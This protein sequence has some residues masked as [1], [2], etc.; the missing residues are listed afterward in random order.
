[1]SN[2][3]F[4]WSNTHQLFYMRGNIDSYIR[5]R[6]VPFNSVTH[7]LQVS[8][9]NKMTFYQSTEDIDRD[10]EEGK[11]FFDQAFT[12]AYIIAA[13]EQCTSHK[14]FYA[15]L[16]G[17]VLSE[18]PNQKLLEY[19]RTLLDHY[20]HSVAYFRSTQEGPTRALVEKVAA[21]VSQDELNTLLLSPELDEINKETF[22]WQE[23]MDRGF[24]RE[25]AL[26]HLKKYPWLC[27]NALT[28]ED[29]LDEL[30]QRA[31]ISMSHD[32]RKEKEELR[33]VQTEILATYQHI[34]QDVLTLQRMALLRPEVK[35]AWAASGY[36]AISILI[37]VAKRFKIDFGTLTFL[38]RHEDVE[39]LLDMGKVLSTQE[40]AE[41]NRCTAYVIREDNLFDFVGAEA[42]Q[43][44]REELGEADAI[45][46]VHEL[47]GMAA[48]PGKFT[49]V[50]YILDVNDPEAARK[51]RDTFRGGVLVT[52]MTQPNI[53][54]IAKW[55]SAIV[56]DEG[57]ML[58]HAAIISR[59]FSIPC[60]VGTHKATKV[61]KD[62]DMVE[63][64]ADKGVVRI[65]TK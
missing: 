51:F 34:G 41:R 9:G 58:S 27:Q 52:S 48:R 37:E 8:H 30:E 36:Y 53:I 54:D 43:V 1:M 50:V 31:T 65:L 18:E 19:W 13:K 26:V 42:E 56:T 4:L 47:H 59:E 22:D 16:G 39:G 44:E 45:I 49:G 12:D 3:T 33:K 11:K 20:A 21:V 23:L 6:N 29:T 46:D 28:H 57:G 15:E 55:A 25:L 60:V 35:S 17:A 7:A 61:L 14:K 38:Y 24:T 64:D 2:Y 5:Y 62:G 10:I 40:V 63:V 32:I